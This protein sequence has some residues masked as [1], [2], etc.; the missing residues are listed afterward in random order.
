MVFQYVARAS[1]WIYL[2]HV[3]IVGLA[4]ISLAQLPVP[5]LGKFLL[6]SAAT[7][8]LTLMTYHVFVH[9][10]WLGMFL[11][12]CRRTDDAPADRARDICPL[13]KVASVLVAANRERPARHVALRKAQ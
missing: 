13:P 4:Q 7:L 5:A 6:A 10:T 9:N 11:D 3:P 12:G 8:A 1:F 2:I